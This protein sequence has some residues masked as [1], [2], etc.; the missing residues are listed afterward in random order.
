L[1]FEIAPEAK[2]LDFARVRVKQ[3]E[4]MDTILITDLAVFYRVGVPAEERAKPQRLLISVEME[5]DFT[6][7]AA[8]DD[9][10]RTVDYHAVCQQLLAFGEGRTW[11][12]IETLAVNIASMIQTEFNAGKVSVEVKKFV[13]PEARYVGVRIV[14]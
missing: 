7:A 12:L 13:I 11:K 2:P 6:A 14:R 1:K 5:L 3:S 4:R 8:S 10:T 9:L